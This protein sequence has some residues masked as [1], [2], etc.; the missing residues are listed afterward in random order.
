MRAE[1][2]S[3]EQ[4][5]ASELAAL[6][7]SV[8]ELSKQNE[9]LRGEIAGL[10]TAAPA[11]A[12][13]REPVLEDLVERAVAKAMANY[14]S[15]QPGPPSTNG[16][17][18]EPGAAF[19]A[20]ASLAGLLSPFINS[21]SREQ[22]WKAAHEAGMTEELIAL[23]EARAKAD[24]KNVALQFELAN[25]YLQPIVQGEAIG[26][27]AGTWSMK[28]DQGYDAVLALDE[29]HWEAR[30]SKAISYSFWPP[31][32]GKQQAAIDHFEILVGKQANMTPRPEFA[33]TYLFL[34]NMYEQSGNTAKAKEAWNL[35]I[36]AF[37]QDRDLRQRLGLE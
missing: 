23:V 28:A 21:D 27:D 3:G 24:P 10:R 8:D 32:Y 29:N 36:A 25:A 15:A 22:L 13:S 19:D 26:I 17:R 33:Q 37:P 12:V 18:S 35:G 7:T 9:D 1:T 30:F 34:G 14:A 5:T 4:T 11:S 16:P 31:V 2:A 6:R 20:D